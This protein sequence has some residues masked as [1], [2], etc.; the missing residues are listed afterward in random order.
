VYYP[1]SAIIALFIIIMQN[2]RQSSAQVDLKLIADARRIFD[3]IYV[4]SDVIDKM[5]TLASRFEMEASAAIQSHNRTDQRNQIVNKFS[6]VSSN[7][8][9]SSIYQPCEENNQVGIRNAAENDC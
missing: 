5:T 7:P 2:P 9:S 8:S 1:F 3:K 4:R 6:A